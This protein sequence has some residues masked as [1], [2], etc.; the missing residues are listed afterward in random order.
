M[1]QRTRAEER[2]AEEKGLRLE[3]EEALQV[4]LDQ[5]LGA[6]DSTAVRL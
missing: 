2:E 3:L 5:Q 1:P 4:R 6:R